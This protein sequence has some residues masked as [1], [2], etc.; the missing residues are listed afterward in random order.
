[1]LYARLEGASVLDLE[2]DIKQDGLSRL[3]RDAIERLR[4]R[5]VLREIIV[6]DSFGKAV[7]IPRT[8]AGFDD[9][10]ILAE[11]DGSIL[12]NAKATSSKTGVTRRV[13]PGEHGQIHFDDNAVYQPELSSHAI[14]H[15][16]CA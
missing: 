16:V 6:I 1:M 3:S 13:Q 14:G 10:A 9:R 7:R 2:R 8:S 4:E 12:A 11:K 15:P 5:A